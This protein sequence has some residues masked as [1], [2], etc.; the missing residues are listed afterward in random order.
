MQDLKERVE[1]YLNNIDDAFKMAERGNCEID[2]CFNIMEDSAKLVKELTA[3]EDIYKSRIEE[4]EVIIQTATLIGWK[5]SELPDSK[6]MIMATAVELITKNLNAAR[7]FQETP[8][9]TYWHKL[10]EVKEREAKLVEA[11]RYYANAE[12]WGEV[13]EDFGNI[14][15]KVLKELGL[16]TKEGKDKIC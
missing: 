11:L 8:E 6:N 16:E 7:P 15:T 10:K 5:E 4:L 1:D 13:L 14:A 3:R 12:C 2:H 9:A